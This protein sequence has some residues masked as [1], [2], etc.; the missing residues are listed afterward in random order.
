M[1]DTRNPILEGLFR[2]E[3]VQVSPADA[4][5][6][7]TS[8]KFGPYYVNTHYLLGSRKAAEA[9]LATI[10]AAVADKEACPGLLRPLFREACRENATYRATIDALCDATKELSASSRIDAISGGERRDWYF[11]LLLAENLGLPHVSL[12]K[13]GSAVRTEP[14]SASAPKTLAAGALSGL[15]VLHVVDI[16]T[17]ASSYVRAWIPFLQELGAVFEDTLSVVD[18]DQGGCEVLAERGVRLH[19]L[20]RISSD[21]FRDAARAGLIGNAQYEMVVG[22]TKDPDAFLATFLSRHPGFLER[23]IAAGGKNAEKAR[24]GIE[25][26]YYA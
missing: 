1:E 7:Y 9:M 24:L 18:R 22:F 23:T 8:G 26:G 13:D 21:L 17:E 10:D 16:V 19:S 2:T 5:F 11:S 12:F 4:P 20:A 15:R 3:A 6:W 25:K 14:D